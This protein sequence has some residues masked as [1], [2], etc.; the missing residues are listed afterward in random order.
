MFRPS[1]KE[2]RSLLPAGGRRPAGNRPIGFPAH[3][4]H[5]PIAAH[6][7]YPRTGA[8]EDGNGQSGSTS[9][10]IG[11]A[12]CS[13]TARSPP[14][15]RSIPC[16]FSGGT[17]LTAHD[18]RH[19]HK[20]PL[21]E[22]FSG[23]SAGRL[24][25]PRLR[26]IARRYEAAYEPVMFDLPLG[27]RCAR[28]DRYCA[29]GPCVAIGAVARVAPAGRGAREAS[30][31]PRRAS[32]WS[33]AAL[34]VASTRSGGGLVA[35]CAEGR[36]GLRPGEVRLIGDTVDDFSAARLAGHRHHPRHD[37]HADTRA[38]GGDRRSCG[39]LSSASRRTRHRSL[40]ARPTM[41]LAAT[42]HSAVT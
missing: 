6:A 7:R 26:L 10:G 13:T 22:A 18:I 41:P 28:G 29:R 16:A 15:S 17:E 31:A 14:R 3:C 19:H 33:R 37:R 40:I 9:F 25:K 11:T 30:W 24:A 27:R 20:R 1:F 21:S 36:L 5:S 34:P 39:R 2:A 8:A 38:P 35:H 12:P 42:N 23:C 4:R 32:S